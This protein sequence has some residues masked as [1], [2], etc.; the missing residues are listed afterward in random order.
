M[1]R[2]T[3]FGSRLAVV[4]VLVSVSAFVAAPGTASASSSTVRGIA[5]FLA[6]ERIG[7]ANPLKCG[8]FVLGL[9]GGSS[10]LAEVRLGTGREPQW[11][12][13]G[14]RIAFSD[15]RD[16]DAE[17]DEEIFVMNAD[18]SHV[19]QLTHN[20]IPDGDPTWSPDGQRLAFTRFFQSEQQLGG[21]IY[22]MNADGTDEIN[23]T[24][25]TP[26]FEE[27]PSWSP[28][29]QRIAFVRGDIWTMN[30]DGSEQRQLTDFGPFASEGPDWSPDGQEIA[31]ASQAPGE[32]EIMAIRPDGTS[33]RIVSNL[34]GSR[35][36]GPS[37][38]LFGT[39]IAFSSD[40]DPGGTDTNV[41]TMT[42]DGQDV[43]QLTHTPVSWNPDWRF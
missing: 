29:G 34:P 28:D 13:D 40:T 32:F 8:I 5:P 12:P 9:R 31:F 2:V 20:E 41:F 3:G 38:G 23:I 25:T 4:A 35:E 27:D 1:W 26:T 11:S 17:H 22:V 14:G 21:D 33:L 24:N 39:Q 15:D 6:F 30:P 19:V 37:W 18:G 16:G 43:V 7:C 10:R 42:P 36:L